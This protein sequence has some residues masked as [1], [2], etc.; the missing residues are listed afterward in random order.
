MG[1]SLGA[2][3]ETLVAEESLLERL[4]DFYALRQKNSEVARA[5]VLSTVRRGVPL[6]SIGNVSKAEEATAWDIFQVSAEVAANSGDSWAASGLEPGK[7][8]NASPEVENAHEEYSD[9]EGNPDEALLI[10]AWKSAKGSYTIY[11][12]SATLDL[13]YREVVGDRTICGTLR[14]EGEGW[15]VSEV[16]FEGEDELLGWFRLRLG[17]RSA[18]GAVDVVQSQVLFVGDEAEGWENKELVRATRHQWGEQSYNEKDADGIP[19]GVP[20][21]GEE[22]QEAGKD[23]NAKES[24]LLIGVWKSAKGSYTIYP[25]SDTLDLMYREVVGDRT[26]CGILREEVEGWWVSEVRFE[27]EDELLGWF[28]LRLGRQSATGAID[29]VQ[30]QVLFVSEEDERWENKELVRATRHQWE[31]QSYVE[32]AELDADGISDGVPVVEEDDLEADK[33]SNT[34]KS[35]PYAAESPTSQPWADIASSAS[36]TPEVK[37]S[38]RMQT[39]GGEAG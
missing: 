1:R 34:K 33:D 30:S 6:F 39:A 28:R 18:S 3:A 31:E 5:L 9:E 23:S 32:Q 15:W 2:V 14:E 38:N 17:R 21:V 7:S 12:D 10:G 11:P 27:G 36:P 13:M 4:V 29:V 22:G 24:L 8:N 26:V 35:S 37:S 25:D 16:R 19:D 20:V